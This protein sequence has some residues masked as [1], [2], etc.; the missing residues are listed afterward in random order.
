MMRQICKNCQK[1][2]LI[3]LNRRIHYIR[4]EQSICRRIIKGEPQKTYRRGEG[5]AENI[6]K[7]HMRH[8]VLEVW[9]C[10]V[11]GALLTDLSHTRSWRLAEWPAAPPPGTP[12]TNINIARPDLV[13]KPNQ[14]TFASNINGRE[15]SCFSFLFP[16]FIYFPVQLMFPLSTHILRST[17]GAAGIGWR[18]AVVSNHPSG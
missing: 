10:W 14:T 18:T 16:F 2:N 9:Q 15:F 3:Y 13:S 6:M 12:T 11:L 17:T 5:G 8:W 1:E 4:L 7:P